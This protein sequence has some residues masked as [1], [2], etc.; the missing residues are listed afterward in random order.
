MGRDVHP[1]QGVE[2][3]DPDAGLSAPRVAN[4]ENGRGNPTLDALDP[5]ASA[6]DTRLTV[7]FAPDGE[8]PPAL[9]ASLVR[10]S[11]GTRFRHDVQVLAESTGAGTAELAGRLLDALLLVT[12]H[13]HTTR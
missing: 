1:H 10:L 8:P 12:L 3:H 6:L 13:P 4:L 11:R 9:P 2:A 7:D 5:L